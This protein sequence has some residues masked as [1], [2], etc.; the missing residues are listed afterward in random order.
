MG[1]VLKVFIS[2]SKERSLMVAQALYD[3][4]PQVINQVEPWMSASSLES[5]KPSI[6]QITEALE[7]V[8]FG[9]ICVTP[10][11]QRETWL[12]FEAGALAKA[13]K[14]ASASAIPLLVGFRSFGELDAPLSNYQAQMSTKADLRKIVHSLNEALGTSARPVAH[15][16]RAFEMWWPELEEKLL[17]AEEWEPT[18]LPVQNESVSSDKRIDQ[19]IQAVKT[20]QIQVEE[21]TTLFRRQPGFNPKRDALIRMAS[22]GRF[23]A[24]PGLT[25]FGISNMDQEE[26]GNILAAAGHQS[27]SVKVDSEGMEIWT[28]RMPSMATRLQVT[29]FLQTKNASLGKMNFFVYDP[30]S[31]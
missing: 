1:W 9:I 29:E 5:G 21:L 20:L 18:D 7:T 22:E 30:K 25:V 15:L 19:V 12:N 10:E 4:L 31:N 6:A 11:N 24:D 2:W 3:W 14:S 26:V 8:N 13:V 27:S 16:D 28:D 23:D 17:E